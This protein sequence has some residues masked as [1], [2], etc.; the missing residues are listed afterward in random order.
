MDEATKKPE[1]K[2][3]YDN[4]IYDTRLSFIGIF[5]ERNLPTFKINVSSEMKIKKRVQ[6]QVLW[7]N[8]L[9]LL[10]RKLK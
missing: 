3:F 10:I 7:I 9:M 4:F 8:V 2:K 6:C 1:Y 5:S